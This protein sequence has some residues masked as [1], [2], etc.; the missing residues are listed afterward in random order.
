MSLP[1]FTIT[2]WR[3]PHRGHG[4]VVEIDACLVDDGLPGGIFQSRQ[5]VDKH[6]EHPQIQHDFQH[7]DFVVSADCVLSIIALADKITYSF[8]E[9]PFTPMLGGSFFGIRIS[10]GYQEVTVIWQGR[11]DD[12]D[13][14]IRNLYSFVDKLAEA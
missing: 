5:D 12:Q 2:I 10:R 14:S 11:Y 9:H 4:Y 8:K 7:R 1:E 6:Q 13:E 3:Y